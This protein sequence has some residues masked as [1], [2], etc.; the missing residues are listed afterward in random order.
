MQSNNTF[1]SGGQWGDSERGAWG[2]ILEGIPC[3]SSWEMVLSSIK[4][5]EVC[6]QGGEGTTRD[7]STRGLTGGRMAREEAEAVVQ[8]GR[9]KPEPG[10]GL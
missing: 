4:P 3:Q 5:Q 2:Q 6:E 10:Q 9:M 7:G 1:G 8:S